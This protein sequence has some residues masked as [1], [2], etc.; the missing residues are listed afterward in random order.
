MEAIICLPV[1]LL[2]SLGVAQFAH[3]WLCRT[4]VQ[5]AAYCGARATLTA[6]SGTA[7][8]GKSHEENWARNAAEI[9]CSPIAFLNPTSENDFALPGIGNNQNI[10]GNGGVRFRNDSNHDAEILT[11]EQVTG[12]DSWH[13]GIRVTMKVPLLFPLAG[14]VIGQMMSLYSNG[15]FSPQA[16]APGNN[17]PVITLDNEVFSRIKLQETAYIVKPFVSTWSN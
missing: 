12:I 9:V 6:P 1:L 11:V 14:P 17:A 3:I 5:Y 8:N 10:P 13:R 15:S 2:V 7:P 4:M 16:A